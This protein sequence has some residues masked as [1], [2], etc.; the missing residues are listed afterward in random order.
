L[1]LIEEKEDPKVWTL[2]TLWDGHKQLPQS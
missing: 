2:D 1:P